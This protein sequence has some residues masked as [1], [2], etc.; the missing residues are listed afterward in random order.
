MRN[1]YDGERIDMAKVEEYAY[2]RAR[3]ANET[4]M[5]HYH[6]HD[7]PCEGVGFKFQHKLVEPREDSTDDS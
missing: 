1:S 3:L 4:T 5:I 7:Q 2:K 6:T